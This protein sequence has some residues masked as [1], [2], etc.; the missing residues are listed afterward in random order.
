MT[1]IKIL[2]L[3]IVLASVALLSACGGG[4]GGGDDAPVPTA[5]TPLSQQVT[6]L[7]APTL[8]L[9][10]NL[11]AA[12]PL[13]QEMVLTFGKAAEASAIKALGS[14]AMTPGFGAPV[15]GTHN[16]TAGQIAYTDESN[17]TLGYTYSSCSIGGFTFNGGTSTVVVA[18]NV[19]AITGYNLTF[20]GLEISGPNVAPVPG[21]LSGSVR[22]TPAATA[23]Q[24]PACT[25]TFGGYVWGLDA[26]FSNGG[27][28][29]GTHQCDCGN[30]SW[31]VTFKNF[32]AISGTAE[33]FGT[34]GSAIVT[35]TG[36]RSFSVTMFVNGTVA[37]YSV[38]V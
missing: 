23:G 12:I 32:T 37:T 20:I 14:L 11:G 3:S 8:H 25:T 34:N 18:R 16:C 2:Q 21:G 4:G 31:N 1:P 19:G 15:P 5:P 13:V 9:D 30:G 27:E 35:R 29:N 7:T 22:C 36:A 6:G 28:A 33:V 24:E 26:I 38:T 10:Q 17:G